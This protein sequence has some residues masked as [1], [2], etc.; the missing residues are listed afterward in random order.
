MP[1]QLILALIAAAAVVLAAL[2]TAAATLFA[3]I[4]LEWYRKGRR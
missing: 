4:L 2:I 3:P 1:L